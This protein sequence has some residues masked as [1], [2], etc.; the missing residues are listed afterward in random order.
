MSKET[1]RQQDRRIKYQPLVDW[2]LLTSERILISD[3]ELSRTSGVSTRTIQ[4]MRL[5][6]TPSVT[7]L[8]KLRKAL[9]EESN[10]RGYEPIFNTDS[11]YSNGSTSTSSGSTGLGRASGT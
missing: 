1:P 3:T 6:T 11:V 2:I 7:N 5:G 10:K 4:R 8:H 9:I